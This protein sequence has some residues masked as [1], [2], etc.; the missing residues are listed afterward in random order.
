MSSSSAA[1]EEVAGRRARQRGDNVPIKAVSCQPPM[2]PA[3][4]RQDHPT[5]ALPNLRVGVPSEMACPQR[6]APGGPG[7]D[8][9]E[10]EVGLETASP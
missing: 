3:L 5:P 6:V 1:C 9:V 8:T 4:P 7:E 10:D 2:R